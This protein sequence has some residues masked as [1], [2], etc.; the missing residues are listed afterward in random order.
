MADAAARVELV[1]LLP[2]KKAVSFMR[3]GAESVCCML[4]GGLTLMDKIQ[5]RHAQEAGTAEQFY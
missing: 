4:D 2:R 1:W 3:K 5:R